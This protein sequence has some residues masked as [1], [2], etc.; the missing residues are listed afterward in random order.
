MSQITSTILRSA[1]PRAF[2]AA[3]GPRRATSP[4]GR[5]DV[6][7]REVEILP[8]RGEH[9]PAQRLVAAHRLGPAA[10][11]DHEPNQLPMDVDVV[12]LEVREPLE[13]HDGGVDV[14]GVELQAAERAQ[15][16]RGD[17]AQAVA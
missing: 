10:E 6:A 15:R 11:P 7:Q 1:L 3:Q 14:G 13:A 2:R 16:A 12:W 9:A 8:E 17:P 5:E 4:T